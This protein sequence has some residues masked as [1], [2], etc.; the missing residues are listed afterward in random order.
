MLLISSVSECCQLIMYV[1][2][3][4]QQFGLNFQFPFDSP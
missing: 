2:T 3:I 1:A 4:L